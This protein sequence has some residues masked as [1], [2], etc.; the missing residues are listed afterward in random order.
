M[1]NVFLVFFSIL[2]YF[3]SNATRIVVS[4]SNKGPNGFKNVTEKHNCEDDGKD[5]HF[6]ICEGSGFES[7][8]WL[9]YQECNSSTIIGDEGQEYVTLELVKQA[10]EFVKNSEST[11]IQSLPGNVVFTWTSKKDFIEVKIYSGNDAK[12]FI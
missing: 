11:G 10:E 3:N 2:M 5:S 4:K 7:C 9:G 6:L 1:K 12:K 8:D